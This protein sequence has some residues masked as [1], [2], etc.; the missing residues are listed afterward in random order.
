M[1]KMNG[2]DCLQRIR[3]IDAQAKVIVLSGYSSGVTTE[4]LLEHGVAKVLQKPIGIEDLTYEISA[5]I[6]S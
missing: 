5:V 3:E 4:Q 2:L 1:P 6:A